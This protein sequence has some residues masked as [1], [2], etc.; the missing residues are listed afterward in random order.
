MKITILSG[1]P[2]KNGTSS[3]LVDYFIKGAESKGH[4]VFRF[5]AAFRKVHPCIGCEHCHTENKKCRFKD[6]MDELNPHLL[7]S[8]IIVFATPLYYFG[9]SAQLKA[10]IDR[11]YAN[12]YNLLNSNKKTILFVTAWNNEDWKMQSIVSQFETL[13]KYMGFENIGT[14]IAVSGAYSTPSILTSLAQIVVV[15]S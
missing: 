9:M 10:A 12:H 5:D 1:S 2:H 15:P 14:K 3:L 7:N 13:N 4:D 11:F 8:D 6:D